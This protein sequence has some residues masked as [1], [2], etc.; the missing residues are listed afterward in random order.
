MLT[1]TPTLPILTPSL[2]TQTPSLLGLTPTLPTLIPTLP[3]LTPTLPT[4]TP[5]LPTLTLTY[6][7]SYGRITRLKQ[8]LLNVPLVDTNK[9]LLVAWFVSN[10]NAHS[11][12]DTVVKGLQNYMQVCA[13]IVSFCFSIK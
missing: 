10:C 5:T 13:L 3:T 2:L 9:T 12:R 1:L 7:H 8:P 6:P 11:G 4:L